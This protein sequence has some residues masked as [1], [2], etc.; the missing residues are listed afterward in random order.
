MIVVRVLMRAG[1]R[2]RIRRDQVKNARDVHA[3]T[4]VVEEGFDSLGEEIDR[5]DSA[6]QHP[7][8][9][10]ELAAELLERG[11]ERGWPLN[12]PEAAWSDEACRG[13]G[14]AL[15]RLRA[16][17]CFFDVYA[18]RQI[19]GHRL[20]LGYAAGSP[21]DSLVPASM[22]PDTRKTPR[23]GATTVVAV[24]AQRSPLASDR[25]RSP[26]SRDATSIRA[27]RTEAT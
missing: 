1:R 24:S 7:I 13:R 6:E 11:H 22:F 19:L 21:R 18:R 9:P 10:A 15:D 20:P 17:A 3:L 8:K 5:R 27:P 25:R 14:N 16:V 2:G 26:N 23:Q 12:R 4:A